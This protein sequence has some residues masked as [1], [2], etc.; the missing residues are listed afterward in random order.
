M[1][2]WQNHTCIRFT[3]WSSETN[4]INFTGG[5]D[6]SSEIGML[7]RFESQRINLTSSCRKKRIILHEI[8]HAL[9]FIHEH[10]RPDRDQYV[11]IHEENI[12]EGAHDQFRSIGSKH[13][14]TFGVPYDYDSI[15]HYGGMFESKNGQLTIE[16]TKDRTAQGR[17]GR[18]TR[19][20]FRNIKLANLLY[21]CNDGCDPTITCPGEGFVGQGCNCY[22]PGDPIQLCSAGASAKAS[23]HSI[24]TRDTSRLL[25]T[26]LSRK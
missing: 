20:S 15:M 18:S 6:C 11:R 25:Q 17:I 23:G 19:L 13:I 10:S 8:G 9:G 24:V 4:Y 2:E 12:K 26:L 3:N 16:T 22:C 5:P 21:T 7:R 1:D 14:D